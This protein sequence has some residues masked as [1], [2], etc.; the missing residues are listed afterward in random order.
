MRTKQA[1]TTGALALLSAAVLWPSVA[2][3]TTTRIYTLGAMNRFIIDDSNRW[4][5]PHMITKFGNLFYVELF[6]GSPSQTTSAPGSNRQAAAN[7]NVN[8]AVHSLDI[9]DTLP[10]QQ[11]AGGGA[12]IAVTDD[13]FVSMHL[14]DYEDPTVP[15][16]L[17]F[18]GTSSRGN[19]NAFPWIPNAAPDAPAASNRKYDLFVAYNLQDLARFGLQLSYGSSKYKRNP[20]SNDPDVTADLQGGVEDRFVD[21]ISVSD[22]GFL[23]G[24][25][26]DL[27]DSA[28]I[29]V[30]LGMNFYS[31]GYSPN[32][33]SD[34]IEGGGGY[35][36]Q[37]D[38][39]A[40]I[41]VSEM[42]EI[43]PAL[44]FRMGKMSGADLGDFGTGLIYNE[45]D[46]REKYFITDVSQSRLL[47]DL[48]AAAHFK[49]TQTIS[50]WGGAGFHLINLAQQYENNIADA[51]D[52]GEVRD[53]PLEFSKQSVS[54][55]ALP[56][57]RIAM[58]A[59]IFSWLDFRAGV[60]KYLRADT[61]TEDAVDDN[62]ADNNRLN[63][64]T[65]DFPFFDYFVG[66]AVHYEGFFCD[67]QLDPRWFQRGPEL[68]SGGGGGN[69]MFVNASLGYN[70]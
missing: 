21:S 59:R 31:L 62:N 44:S 39:R 70:F 28:T 65:R 53:Q 67:L 41:G 13:L 11:S 54:I 68:F 16:F 27:G 3:A 6:G 48:G 23:L 66:A 15:Q 64:V 55:D 10:I 5:Y 9:A 57:I 52:S 51:P 38:V 4:L 29:D 17:T 60:V 30:G 1:I 69:P 46:T 45:D 37:A 26:L 50:F 24:G 18:L 12:I 33:R 49:P 8:V 25:G 47:F 2:Q 63:D 61:V 58:E 19:P 35:G 42:W 56:Y 7:G 32:E 36:L 22:F 20:N 14:S 34:L 43:V 40:M